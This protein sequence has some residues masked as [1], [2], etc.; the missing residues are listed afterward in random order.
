VQGQR[1]AARSAER[2]VPAALGAWRFVFEIGLFEF[3]C[4]CVVGDGDGRWARNQ[5]LALEHNDNELL[6]EF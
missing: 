4:E 5:N 3:E 6:L 2:W 1:A